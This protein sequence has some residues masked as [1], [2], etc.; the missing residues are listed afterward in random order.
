MDQC[1]FLELDVN[2]WVN[3]LFNQQTSFH[4]GFSLFVFVILK[5]HG[6]DDFGIPGFTGNLV[7]LEIS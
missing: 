2:R 4:E 5:S 7:S 1:F 6:V 3:V